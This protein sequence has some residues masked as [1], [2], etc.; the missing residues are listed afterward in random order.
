MSKAKT[1]TSGPSDSGSSAVCA[2]SLMSELRPVLLEGESAATY[3][4]VVAHLTAAVQPKD[5]IE[6]LWVAGLVDLMWQA[7]RLRRLKAELMNFSAA[8]GL[9]EVLGPLVGAQEASEL[10]TAWYARKPAALKRVERLLKRAAKTIDA[11]MAQTLS[12]KLDDI[13]RIDRMLADVEGRRHVVLREI[14]R[15]RV[16]VAAPRRAATEAIEDGHYTDIP[17]EKAAE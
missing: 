13:E 2:V 4:A 8:K 3:D 1:R 11:V 9:E 14:D 10:A 16:A 7:F 5:I 15:H 17:A 6:E 12:I